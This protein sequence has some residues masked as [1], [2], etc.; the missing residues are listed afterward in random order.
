MYQG[1]RDRCPET[2]SGP[3]RIVSLNGRTNRS[4]YQVPDLYTRV[5]MDRVRGYSNRSV[6]LSLSER[7]KTN[8]SISLITELRLSL[9]KRMAHLFF[10]RILT[11]VACLLSSRVSVSFRLILTVETIF[12][13][14]CYTSFRW[15]TSLNGQ[16][17]QLCMNN[18]TE[19]K[20]KPKKMFHPQLITYQWDKSVFPRSFTYLGNC[21]QKKSQDLSYTL[22][23]S[24]SLSLSLLTTSPLSIR[25]S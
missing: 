20:Y 11:L 13:I 10:E 25:T 3:D 5:F 1:G 6:T 19:L 12:E 22:S 4:P 8:Y 7:K 15:G 16:C 2:G 18:L 14:Q 21:L 9:V 23:S 17:P 24:W